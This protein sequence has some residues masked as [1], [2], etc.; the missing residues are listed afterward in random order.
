MKTIFYSALATA[1]CAFLLTSCSGDSPDDTSSEDVVVP[2]ELSITP[3]KI[4]T[5]KEES[6]KH[7]NVTTNLTFDKLTISKG[8]KWVN[9]ILNSEKKRLVVYIEQNPGVSTRKSQFIVSGGGVSDTLYVE[10]M[11]VDPEVIF[12]ENSFYLDHTSQVVTIELQTNI[13][14]LIVTPKDSWVEIMDVK[15]L[16]PYTYKFKVKENSTESKKTTTISFSNADKSVDKSVM[17]EQLAPPPP[18]DLTMAYN[19]N[20]IYF[21]PNDITPPADYERRLSEL[22]LWVRDF[23][24]KNMEKNGY[25]YRGFGLRTLDAERVDIITIKGKLA[26]SSYPY[27]GGNGAVQSELKEYFDANPTVSGGI[28]NLIIIPSYTG[29]PMS[30][31]GPPFYGVGRTCFA[32]DYE[33]MDIKYLGEISDK[34]TLLTKWFGGLAHE[35]GHGLNLPH[36]RQL[37][38]QGLGTTLMGAG[39]YTLGLEPTFLSAAS[40]ALLNNCQVFAPVKKEF[41]QPNSSVEIESFYIEHTPT[42]INVKAK[43]Q[44][45]TKPINA[46][47]I[48]VDDYP[49][50]GVNENY[51]AESWTVS[52]LTNNQFSIDIPLSAIGRDNDLFRV[53]TWFLFDDGTYIEESHDFDRT[54][55]S[56]YHFVVETDMARDGWEAV[57]SDSDNSSPASLMLDGDVATLWHSQ[58]QGGKP[59]HPHTL[60]VTMDKATE[61]RGLSFVQRQSMHGA[62]NEFD[63]EVSNDGTTW[64]PQGRHKLVYAA[65][66]QFVYLPEPKLVKSFR[67]K[68]V[69]NY[70][71]SDP[72]IAT[73]AEIGAF[74]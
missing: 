10:Q 20:L 32:L 54:N 42:T 18:P 25:G 26:S 9:C 55:L 40:C 38:G 34:G 15:S 39:N 56:D 59:G 36:N 2:T 13:P 27:G 73:L 5:T 7:I 37:A 66:K 52:D 53:R 6:V 71:P 43:F 21:I 72:N 29:D 45:Q 63:I 16:K 24:A 33:Y 22:L 48:Y 4:V 11:G 70:T 50:T 28:H 47:N 31:G 17:I 19:L 1:Y 41:Y 30:P 62:I 8:D 67:I 68:T 69:S 57:A 44:N 60:T 3:N 61:I 51:D 74:E 35:L 58:W 49:Y 46:V 64:E 12:V 14:N 65:R 23:Y